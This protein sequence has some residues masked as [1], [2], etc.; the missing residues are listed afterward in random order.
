[1]VMLRRDVPDHVGTM[2]RIVHMVEE[3]IR[4]EV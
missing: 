4:F 2:S 3:P 1:M